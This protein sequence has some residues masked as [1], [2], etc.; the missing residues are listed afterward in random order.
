MP[1]VTVEIKGLDKLISKFAKSPRM[2]A[3]NLNDGI[4]QGG[5]YVERQSKYA[6]S[7]GPTKAIDTGMLRRSISTSFK[8]L[9]AIIAPH[10]EYA[11]FVHEGTR[12]M[13]ARPFM[14][15]G[16]DLAKRGLGRIFQ[17]MADNI[18]KELGD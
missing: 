6:I 16:L 10:T 8:P 14:T 1:N 3:R 7:T 11:G 4:K 18:A 12:Y 17:K 2:I 15:R 9:S 5:F 13:H